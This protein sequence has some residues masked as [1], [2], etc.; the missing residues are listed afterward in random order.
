MI[1]LVPQN[2]EA[3]AGDASGGRLVSA[4]GYFATVSV[5]TST[6]SVFSLSWISARISF[7]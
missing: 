7:W 3:P 4:A 5:G 6:V 2:A 1:R